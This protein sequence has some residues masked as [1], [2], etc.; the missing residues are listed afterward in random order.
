MKLPFKRHSDTTKPGVPL[1]GST[2][3]QTMDYLTALAPQKPES[4]VCPTCRTSLNEEH[5]VGPGDTA[6]VMANLGVMQVKLQCPGCHT[7]FDVTLPRHY[8]WRSSID[9]PGWGTFP[10]G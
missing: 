3:S 9:I 7:V 1:G 10:G 8:P 4:P 2:G 6:A 5:Q